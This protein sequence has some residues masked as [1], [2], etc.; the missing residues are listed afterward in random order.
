M[1]ILF[2]GGERQGSEGDVD[3]KEKEKERGSKGELVVKERN[4]T[5]TDYYMGDRIEWVLGPASQPSLNAL[6]L[7]GWL[8]GYRAMPWPGLFR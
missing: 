4:G 1:R 6:S 8:A 7:A 5:G 3:E 2:R